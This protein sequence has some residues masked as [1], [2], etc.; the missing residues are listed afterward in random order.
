MEN[1]K[2]L[3]QQRPPTCLFHRVCIGMQ[4]ICHE[5]P[6]EDLTQWPCST[7]K[8]VRNWLLDP[9]QYKAETGNS[10][11]PWC[12]ADDARY[13]VGQRANKC[14][15]GGPRDPGPNG[16]LQEGFSRNL[17]LFKT[18]RKTMFL[19]N[20]FVLKHWQFIFRICFNSDGDKKVCMPP[21]YHL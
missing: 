13:E 8:K 4:R 3:K 12:Q 11:A 10:K 1:G 14:S 15:A 7:P 5:K 18:N 17:L 21:A 6:H 16:Y 20:L 9:G 2:W 19:Q